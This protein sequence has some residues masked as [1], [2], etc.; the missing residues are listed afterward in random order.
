MST[1]RIRDH[2]SN[3]KFKP[4]IDRVQKNNKWSKD[5]AEMVLN[6]YGRFM[7]LIKLYPEHSFVPCNDVDE[8]WHTHLIYTK[9][10]KNFCEDV[11]GFFLHHNP[12]IT[13]EDGVRM[14]S[15]YVKTLEIYREHFGNNPD[16]EIWKA[17]HSDDM[18]EGGTGGCNDGR[19]W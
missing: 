11:F 12:L 19:G 7:T 13:E 9:L 1:F 14:V 6:E 18:C 3:P 10:Y 16:C 2:L 8:V 15:G 5:K 4:V 17:D